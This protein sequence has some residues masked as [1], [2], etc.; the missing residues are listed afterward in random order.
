MENIK[1]VDLFSELQNRLIIGTK[2]N[3]IICPTCKGLRFRLVD[4]H[5]EQCRDCHTGIVYVCKHC[6]QHNSTNYCKCDE[7]HKERE[8]KYNREQAEK[9]R[10]A[11]EKAEKIHYKDYDGYYLINDRLCEIDMLEEWIEELLEDGESVPEYMWAVVGE[12]CFSINLLD[13]ISD[14]CEDGYE[15]MYSHLDTNSELLDQAQILIEKWEQQQGE[16]LLSYGETYKKVII[17]KDLVD[18]VRN[19]M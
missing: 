14:K 19:K 5:I 16:S 9:D 4:S 8:E 18:V 3:E 2:E 11:F 1:T 15:D 6:N 10:L 13:I 12:P 7:A 17:I